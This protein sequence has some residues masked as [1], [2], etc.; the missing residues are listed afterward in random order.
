MAKLKLGSDRMECNTEG[1][2]RILEGEVAAQAVGQLTNAD[3]PRP[4]FQGTHVLH[5]N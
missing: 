5:L 4:S 3:K 1:I 2:L